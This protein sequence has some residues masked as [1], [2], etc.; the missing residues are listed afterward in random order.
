MGKIDLQFHPVELVS[1]E[2]KCQIMELSNHEY[3]SR[4]AY[5]KVENFDTYINGL[6]N[7]KHI[8][9]RFNNEI[10]GWATKFLRDQEKWFVIILSSS[11]HGQYIGSRLMEQIKVHG[12]HYMAG[13]LTMTRILKPTVSN[14]SRP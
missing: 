8:L 7:P 1:L 2:E 5:N 3:P 6:V 12:P 4:L 14:T 10:V 11:I 9:V 13:L